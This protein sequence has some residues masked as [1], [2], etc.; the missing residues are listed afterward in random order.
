MY[1][2]IY[3]FS[4][5][6]KYINLKNNRKKQEKNENP[7]VFFTICGILKIYK[8][9][10][11]IILNKKIT[12][13]L[14]ATTILATGFLLTSRIEPVNP[15]D[16]MIPTVHAQENETEALIARIENLPPVEDL[17]EKHA[18]EVKALMTVYSQLKMADRILVTNYGV[19]KKD[20]DALV[21]KGFLTNEDN[22]IIQEKEIQKKKQAS[23]ELSGSAV[24]Q[25][26]EF[27]FQSDG[28]K[29]TTIII[30][31]TA[32]AD[33]DGKG[34]APNRIVLTGPD[35]TTYPVSNTSISMSDGEKLKVDLTWTDLY[36]Q[37]DFSK[38]SSGKWTLETSQAVTFSS[39]PFSGV[40]ANVVS[41][42]D[43][44]KTPT[45]ETE[46][47]PKKK[48]NKLVAFLFFVGVIVG[49]FFGIR[50]IISVIKGGT[51]APKADE[52]LIDKD[53]GPKR[54][55]DEEQLALMRAELKQQ[56]QES[57]QDEQFSE[58]IEDFHQRDLN[59]M[60][61]MTRA[62][63]GPIS[64]DDDIPEGSTTKQNQENEEDSGFNMEYEEDTSVLRKEDQ[65]EHQKEPALDQTASIMTDFE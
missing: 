28:E 16:A 53:N 40:A 11:G 57:E 65:P 33:G 31:Y 50:K 35:G 26:K 32:D 56:R 38:A 13:G 21:K 20:F 52:S 3:V 37:M 34:D 10:K 58:K 6:H 60:P 62:K 22:T 12:F 36:L 15:F 25:E 9:R 4:Y 45:T 18:E 64:Y 7:A 14:L 46:E 48:G 27:T 55:S 51:D 41:E 42:D 44:S 54:L 23:K 19:L 30:R 61:E 29:G 49:G 24:S 59:F 39:K 1:L 2:C 63:R 8:K 5:L 17:T 47:K 43:K